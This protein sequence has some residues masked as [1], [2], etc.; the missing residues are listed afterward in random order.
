MDIY[1]PICEEPW[2]MYCINEEAEALAERDGIPYE[3][4]YRKVQHA[5]YKDGC[6]AFPLAYGA[7]TYC[8]RSER[9]PEDGKLSKS[10]AMSALIDIL[11]DD[12]DGIAAMMD[13]AIYL[14]QVEA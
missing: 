5:F 9:V 8:K 13:D 3:Q 14:G 7:Q 11:G 4:A 1:C 6:N 2:D 12:V 10:M